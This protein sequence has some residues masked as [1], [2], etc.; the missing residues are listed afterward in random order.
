MKLI[1][2][3]ENE[4]QGKERLYPRDIRNY[5]NSIIPQENIELKSFF[6]WHEH[7]TSPVIYPMPNRKGFAIISYKSD[8]VAYFEKLMELIKNSSELTFKNGIKNSIKTI[9]TT[10][11]NYTRFDNGVVERKMR[12]PLVIASSKQDYAKARELSKDEIDMK[13]L[14]ELTRD[15]IKQSLI[16]TNKDWFDR[17]LDFIDDV[18][19]LFKN[20]E[21][22]PIKYKENEWYPAVRATIISNIEL[23]E[24][25]GYKIGLGYGELMRLKEMDRRGL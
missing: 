21:Y 19:I 23:P 13:A 1:C 9:F 8:A 20:M 24:F 3:Y 7:S 6:A 2:L 10:K 22:I 5:I 15:A 16:K 25:I 17:E 4:L 11:Y 18:F 12:T 14:E